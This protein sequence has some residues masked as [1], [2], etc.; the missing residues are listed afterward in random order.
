MSE[1]VQRRRFLRQAGLGALGWAGV[2]GCRRQEPASA[3]AAGAAR[4]PA[5]AGGPPARVG[6]GEHRLMELPYGLDQLAIRDSA[7]PAVTGLSARVV[8]WHYQKHHAGY[9]KALNEIEQELAAMASADARA[10]YSPYSELKRREAFNASGMVL[11]DLYW[12]QLTPGGAPLTASMAVCQQLL[13]D[14]GSLE[15]WRRDFVATAETPST[16]WAILALAPYDRRLHNYACSLHDLGGVWGAVPLLA[17]DVWEHAYYFDYGP[18]RASYIES[19]LRLV[20]WP[21]VSERFSR[22]A[23]GG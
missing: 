3:L 8:E 23:G 7:S 12:Q 17:L 10:N 5:G 2:G 6:P 20:N 13:R 21:L 19:F 22:W 15:R 14:F 4:Q 18:D 9:V 1:P 11:H 16:G